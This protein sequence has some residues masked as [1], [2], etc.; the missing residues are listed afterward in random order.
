MKFRAINLDIASIDN[1]AYDIISIFVN[2][3]K[4]NLTRENPSIVLHIKKNMDLPRKLR[5]FKYQNVHKNEFGGIQKKS[6]N[7]IHLCIR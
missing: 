6:G 3:T 2:Y 1:F 4:D 7:V 5:Y